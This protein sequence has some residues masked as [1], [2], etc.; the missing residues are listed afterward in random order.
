M[1]RR[2]FRAEPVPIPDPIETMMRALPEG[3][4]GSTSGLSQAIPEPRAVDA[5]LVSSLGDDGLHYPVL[6]LDFG[7]YVVPSSTPGHFHLYLERAMPWD[8][9]AGLLVALA[10]A[11]VIERGYADACLARGMTFVRMPGVSK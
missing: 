1:R 4:F 11:G 8:T 10:E 3:S 7:A 2:Y 6:D 9:Y 5:N